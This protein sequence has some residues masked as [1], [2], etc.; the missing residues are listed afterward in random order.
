MLNKIVIKNFRNHSDTTINFSKITLLIGA[1]GTGK[2]GIFHALCVLKQ[3]FEYEESPDR[4]RMVGNEVN[5]GSRNQVVSKHDDEQD[6]DMSIGFDFESHPSHGTPET[7]NMTYRVV[8]TKQ[9]G[10]R[11]IISTLGNVSGT[12]GFD[13]TNGQDVVFNNNGTDEIFHVNNSS[14]LSA[15]G[16]FVSEDLGSRSDYFSTRTVESFLRLLRYVPVQRG[17]SQFKTRITPG[18]PQHIVNSQGNAQLTQDVLGT[19]H[20]DQELADKISPYMKKLFSKNVRPALVQNGLGNFIS[21]TYG[22]ENDVNSIMGTSTFYDK[23]VFSFA[24]NSGFG[25]N[26]MLFLFVQLLGSPKGSII[27]IEEPEVSLHPV[28]QRKLMDIVIDIVDQQNKQIILTTHSEHLVMALFAAI[29][30][31]KLKE[32]EL[33][34]YEFEENEGVGTASKIDS[35]R[36]ALMKFLGNDSQM[37]L[38]YVDAFGKHDQWVQDGTVGETSH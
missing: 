27:M 24:A 31:G 26:Q 29:D 25:L 6:I 30:S 7:G 22:G 3:T 19:I 10:K 9:Y 33:G 37:I 18:K 35:L 32:S 34:V 1:N 21:G 23:N 13:V 36:G 11:K 4:L 17:T 2:S 12:I 28:A 14:G 16:A 5:L 20:Y 15:R 38:E 8:D